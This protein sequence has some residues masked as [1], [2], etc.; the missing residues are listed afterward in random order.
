LPESNIPED[1]A[2]ALSQQI[3]TNGTFQEQQVALASLGSMQNQSAVKALGQYL[4]W[5]ETKKAK[6]EIELDII[7]A[8]KQQN[9]GELIARLD[10]YEASKPSNDPLS[11]Y[12]E[13][14]N[15]GESEKGR[16]IFNTH[17]A[18]QCV[19]C[20]TIFETGGTMGPGLSGVGAK[21]SPMELLAALI[22]PSASFA[23]GY[24]MITVKLENGESVTGL[25][26]S[27]TDESVTIRSGSQEARTFNR[28]EI[29][30]QT[31]I[32]SSMPPMGQ[33]LNKKEIRDVMAFLGTLK[34]EH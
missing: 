28:E 18:A 11:P 25:V 22:T 7:E 26:Q 30:E 8:V 29:V 4:G 20:H 14:L 31:S 1:Q 6:T 9:N 32:P 10:A 12:L 27:E 33:I 15:G 16:E 34:E 24:H 2:V 5:L 23:E 21:H 19:R 3:M 13:T 17:E